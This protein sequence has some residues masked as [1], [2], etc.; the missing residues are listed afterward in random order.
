MKHAMLCIVVVAC[1]DNHPEIQVFEPTN[2]TRLMIE[3]Y[4]FD[5]GTRVVQPTAFYDRR[6]HARCTPQ[7]WIDGVVRC[8]PD[9]EQAF[10][11]DDMCEMPFGRATKKF[12]THFIAQDLRPDDARRMPA[13]VFAVGAKADPIAMFYLRQGTAEDGKPICTG[14]YPSP[15]DEEGTQYYEVAGEVGGEDLV[16]ITETQ[17]GDGRLALNVRRS[18][19]GALVPFGFH[20]RDLDVDCAP[21]PRGAG[22]VCEPQSVDDAVFFADNTCTQPAVLVDDGVEPPVAARTRSSDGCFAYHAIGE[23]APRAY[24]DTGGGCT[25][26]TTTARVL[27]LGPA[28]ELAAITREPDDAPKHRVQ[29][30]LASDGDLHVYADRMFDTATRAEC[31]LVQDGDTLRCLPTAL[32]PIVRLFLPGCTVE[33]RFA[34]VPMR[35]CE[36]FAFAM[37]D[38]GESLELHAIGGRFDG[39][40]YTLAPFGF[41]MPYTP[42]AGTELFDVGPLL[43]DD[44]F[45]GAVPFGAR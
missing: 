3:Q 14:P 33:R 21:V 38:N 28:V 9:A 10:Y 27:A 31:Q 18:D 5:D 29:R 40:A 41:C 16:A 2:G 15:F 36:P 45:V 20:D 24:R 37:H 22:G 25:S 19:D 13:R 4:Q 44:T 32:A 23:Q 39:T 8:L 34:E 6:I 1:G 17:I 35:A 30:I 42:A 7:E 26:V 12:P 43:P 11:R